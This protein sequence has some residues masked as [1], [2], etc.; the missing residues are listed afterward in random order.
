MYVSG[1]QHGEFIPIQNIRGP[2]Q[3]KLEM[4]HN[5]RKKRLLQSHDSPARMEAVCKLIPDNL[6]GV[7]LE[8]TG[9]Y[10]GCY[11]A[12]TKHQD[13]LKCVAPDNQPS[14]IR[15]LC[16]PSTSF[17]NIF[18]PE[19]IFCG[20]LESKVSGRTEGCVQFASFKRKEAA[21]T[22]IESQA[23]E[24]GDNHLHCKVAGEGLFAREAR[25]HKSCHNSLKLRYVNYLRDQANK[26][27]ENKQDEKQEAH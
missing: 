12:F 25:F 24:I 8:M 17:R 10:R 27:T 9:Y 16:K 22:R 20:K 23:L 18:P 6:D 13:H 21:W 11:E 19:C 14:T 26:N 2:P 1:I 7:Y 3:E 15:S 4:L 5:V